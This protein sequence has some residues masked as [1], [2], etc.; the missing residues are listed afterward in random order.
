MPISVYLAAFGVVASL[1]ILRWSLLTGP[2][3]NAAARSNLGGTPRQRIESKPPSPRIARVVDRIPFLGDDR[4]LQRRISSANLTWRSANV[5]FF[6]LVTIFLTLL[7]G[8]LFALSAHSARPVLLFIV[9]GVVFSMLPS[10]VIQK[11]SIAH[12]SMLEIQL[13]DILDR[14]KIMLEAGLGF[15]SALANVV[16]NR[17]GPGYDEF[18]RVLQ[19]LQLGVPRNEALQALSDRTTITDLRVVLAAVLQS[20]KYGLPLVEVLRVQTDE[21]RDKRWQ[22]AQEQTMKV[23]VKMIFPLILCILPAFFV[24]LVGPS[25]VQ[26][27]KSF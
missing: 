2:R 23:Q 16:K 7:L 24:V 9:G 26:L 8:G 10:Y 19:D 5:R 21:L 25:V 13:P 4:E 6:Q 1:F 11:K 3:S 17:S 12:Q 14:L 22:R 20:S 27:L 18:K 15:D